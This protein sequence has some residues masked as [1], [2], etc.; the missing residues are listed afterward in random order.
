MVFAV[1]QVEVLEGDRGEVVTL[2]G[3]EEGQAGAGG[4]VAGDTLGGG[5]WGVAVVLWEGDAGV[6]G[7]ELVGCEC[8]VRRLTGRHD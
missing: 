3:C 2:E 4:W 7:E 6:V 5:T 1:V 8:R